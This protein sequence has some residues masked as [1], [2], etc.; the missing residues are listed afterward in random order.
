MGIRFSLSAITISYRCI[1]ASYS[2]PFNT[3]YSSIPN[4]FI[5]GMFKCRKRKPAVKH[6]RL[7]FYELILPKI[8]HSGPI[9]DVW[10]VPSDHA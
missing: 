3:C 10:S 6:T 1:F 5:H 4:K 2:M 8:L 7:H 9:R